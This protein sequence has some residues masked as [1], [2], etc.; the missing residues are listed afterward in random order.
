MRKRTDYKNPKMEIRI[1]KYVEII[2]T[3]L[4]NGGEGT[5]NVGDLPTETSEEGEL[6]L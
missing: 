4:I 6:P 1:F 2:R 3:S 5:G